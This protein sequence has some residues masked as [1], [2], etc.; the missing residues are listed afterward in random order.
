MKNPET[1]ITNRIVSTLQGFGCLVFKIHG[2]QYQAAGLP[3]LLV[4]RG[5]MTVW[6]E[7]KTPTGKLR[8]VQEARITQ[9]RRYGIPVAVVRSP[10]EALEFASNHLPTGG[11]Q[12][13]HSNGS[14]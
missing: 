9:I 5:G 4:H 14:T 10:E 11:S 6:M 13:T 12:C 8:P 7:V 2:S 1:I 3:D